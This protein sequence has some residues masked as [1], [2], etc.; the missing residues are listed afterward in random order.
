M[1][2]E[3]N[4]QHR[5]RHD[6]RNKIQII[7]GYLQLLEDE[8]LPEDVEDMLG[9]IMKSTKDSYELLEEWKEE[10]MEKEDSS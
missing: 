5:I 2:E 10:Q 7:Q 4:Y 6:L 8:E 1:A 3:E 9:K